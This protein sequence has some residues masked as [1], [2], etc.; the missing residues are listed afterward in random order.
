[1]FKALR[2]QNSRTDIG[3]GGAGRQ[4]REGC[5]SPKRAP[6]YLPRQAGKYMA[7]GSMQNKT[8]HEGGGHLPL[9]KWNHA[10]L[11][12]CHAL[13]LLIAAR[14]W[15]GWTEKR[16]GK[17]NS[18]Y[19]SG[20][21]CSSCCLQQLLLFYLS[22]SVAS[23]SHSSLPAHTH[24]PAL[25]TWTARATSSRRQA[26]AGGRNMGGRRDSCRRRLLGAKALPPTTYSLHTYSTCPTPHYLHTEER[27][28][29][30]AGKARRCTNALRHT[31]WAAGR[32]APS[33]T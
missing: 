12:Y 9:F 15:C 1:L 24:T 5:A 21:C 30:A 22:S 27:R 6:P 10:A 14:S 32:C 4:R 23:S 28:K 13:R 16:D 7:E 25:Y 8:L 18:S 19:T 31:R 3:A 2:P 33:W 17:H 29:H 26:E 11:P 20:S